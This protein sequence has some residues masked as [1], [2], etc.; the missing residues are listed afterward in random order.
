MEEFGGLMGFRVSDLIDTYG[1]KNHE[2]EIYNY[3]DKKLLAEKSI[4]GIFLGYYERWD[5]IKN[6]KTSKDNGFVE[7]DKELE[8]C[9]FNFEKIDN[10]Q[11][12]IHDYFKFL[13][14]GFGRATDQLSYSVRRKLLSRPDAIK[15]A[16]KLEGKYPKS[17]MGKSLKDILKKINV[18]ESE[19]VKICDSFTNKKI[20]KTNNLNELIK[21][22]NNNLIKIKY[23]N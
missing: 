8:G 12:G 19:F 20:F 16:Q 1:F 14:F 3:P 11:H 6:Y 13:K 7:Y 9:Y 17:Y 4:T 21:D 23:D 5:S 22:E 15:L 18:T 10:Y 2:L